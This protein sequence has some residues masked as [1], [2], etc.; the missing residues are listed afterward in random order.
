MPGVVDHLIALAFG[1]L[2]GLSFAIAF[3]VLSFLSLTI[4]PWSVR[5]VLVVF[6]IGAGLGFSFIEAEDGPTKQFVG[7]TPWLET[8]FHEHLG[9]TVEQ[10]SEQTFEAAW[11]DVT[12]HL[13]AG[14]PVL[15]FV[16]I[17]YLPYYDSDVHFSPHVVLAVDYDEE[18]VTL[19]DSEHD[20]LQQMLDVNL[21]GLMAATREA[22]PGL[23]DQNS[24]HIV[25][26]SSVAGQTANETSGGYSATKF[27]VNA[28][29]ESLRKEIADSDVRVTVVS[30]GAVETELGDHIP[31]EQTKERMADLTDD[32]APLDPVDIANGIAYALSQPARVSVNELVIRPTNQR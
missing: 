16:D 29:S 6:G 27:G 22:L 23:L 32:L 2:D 4:V 28:F 24:G 10:G 1:F 7:R 30:P 25:N 21:K 20:D 5:V 26:I 12:A 9:V 19:A 18:S 15:L 8:A 14:R 11:D 3:G 31:D 17:F 13:D